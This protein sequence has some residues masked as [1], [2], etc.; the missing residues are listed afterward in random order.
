MRGG[1]VSFINELE[2]ARERVSVSARP[3]ASLEFARPLLGVRPRDDLRTARV[4]RQVVPV[5]D[6]DTVAEPHDIRRSRRALL[7]ARH[8]EALAEAGILAALNPCKLELRRIERNLRRL[9]RFFGR[10]A[11]IATLLTE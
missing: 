5:L 10:L 8:T 9:E 7:V 4:G 11:L 2:A 3:A 1:L 6:L